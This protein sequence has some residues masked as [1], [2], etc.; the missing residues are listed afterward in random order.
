V[1]WQCSYCDSKGERCNRQAV[2]RLHFALDHPFNFVDVC[3]EHRGYYS[4]VAWHH[5][6]SESWNLREEKE[7]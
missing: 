2:W 4:N 1:R 5:T 6:L 3:K 7:A